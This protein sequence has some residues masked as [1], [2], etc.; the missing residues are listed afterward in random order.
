MEDNGGNSI[1]MCANLPEFSVLLQFTT[2]I[3]GVLRPS[4]IELVRLQNINMKCNLSVLDIAAICDINLPS[5]IIKTTRA[6]SK[7][8]SQSLYLKTDTFR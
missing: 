4:Q 3:V 5:L 1:S 6:V 7:C 8:F 2:V